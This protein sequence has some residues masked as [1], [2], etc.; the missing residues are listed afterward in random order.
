MKTVAASYWVRKAERASKVLEK[1][2]L[3]N[4]QG[5]PRLGAV[6]PFPS[7]DSTERGSV[8]RMEN[9]T[10]GRMGTPFSHSPRGLCFRAR[11]GVTARS[12]GKTI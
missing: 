6:P 9:G 1:V 5:K 2:L 12:L 7:S 10:G 8:G 3:G 11:K 4:N